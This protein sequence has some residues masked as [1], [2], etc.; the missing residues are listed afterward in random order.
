MT[1]D[2]T[3]E[4]MEQLTYFGLFAFFSFAG[5]LTIKGSFPNWQHIGDS[6]FAYAGNY[7]SVVSIGGGA[8]VTVGDESFK[9]F[10]GTLILRGHFPA[11]KV[12]GTEAFSSASN[13]N[14]QI[15]IQCR[16]EL[17]SLGARAFE[18]TLGLHDDTGESCVCTDP[19]AAANNAT[20][21]TTTTNAAG[22][23]CKDGG[24]PLTPA[25]YMQGY[26]AYKDAVCVPDAAFCQDSFFCPN[27]PG[28]SFTG[29]VILEN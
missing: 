10:Q 2:V 26:E 18:N 6:A 27:G 14:N 29:D 22:L 15:V 16:S 1:R 23:A 13:P 4:N 28:L 3:L 21:I 17:W 19:C 5:T 7:K 9:T 12:I 20:T 25:L 11:W 8:L 24:L